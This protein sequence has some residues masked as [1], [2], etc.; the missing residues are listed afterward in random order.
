M[1]GCLDCSEPPRIAPVTIGS[2]FV[3]RGGRLESCGCG[4]LDGLL[5]GKL[6]LMRRLFGSSGSS[7]IRHPLHPASACFV[8]TVLYVADWRVA[9]VDKVVLFVARGGGGSQA[10]PTVLADRPPGSPLA[11]TACYYQFRQHWHHCL[12]GCAGYFAHRDG[13][14]QFSCPPG[15]IASLFVCYL[16][17]LRFISIVW[18]F[19]TR[20]SMAMGIRFHIGWMAAIDPDSV[21]APLRSGMLTGYA[22][23]WTL[24]GVWPVLFSVIP[25]DSGW[26][27]SG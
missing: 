19:D 27:P 2:V 16:L 14:S 20:R 15:L 5:D 8:V 13:V 1:V 17:C 26:L 4:S 7:S 23:S 12:F 11:A 10:R 24:G 21:R 18:A 25:A 9:A 22:C 6:R 3:F